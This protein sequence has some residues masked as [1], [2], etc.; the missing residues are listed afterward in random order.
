VAFAFT[1][2]DVEAWLNGWKVQN[3][4]IDLEQLPE[5]ALETVFRHICSSYDLAYRYHI[6]EENFTKV[7]EIVKV[8]T[9]N[10]ANLTR[11]FV[12]GSVE[13]LDILRF[14]PGINPDNIQ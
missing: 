4:S 9:R 6:P 1:N 11:S 8:R 12:K 14:N 2:K 5:V 10:R 7:L 13:V 3:T